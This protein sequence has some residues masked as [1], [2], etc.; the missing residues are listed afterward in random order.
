[1]LAGMKVELVAAL[2]ASALAAQPVPEMQ[3]ETAKLRAMAAAAPH[4]P[5]SMTDIR[6]LAPKPDWELGFVSSAAAAP[7]GTVYLLQ[8]GLTS[9]PVVVVDRSGHVIRSWGKGLYKIPHSIRLDSAGDVWTV[10]AASSRVLKFSPDG[11]LLLEIEVGG[12]PQTRSA[13]NGAAD[14]AFSKSGRVFVADGYGNARVVEYTQ[15]GAKVREWGTPGTGPGQ[16]HLPHGIA[17]DE[18]D[19]IFVADRE[20]G[21]IQRFTLEGAY[22]GEFGGLG[23]TFSVTVAG[24]AL[25]IGTQPRD[26]PNGAPG[27]LMKLDRK[28]GKVLGVVESPG[29][30][31]VT[32]TAQGEMFTGVRPD[33]LLWFKTRQK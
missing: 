13:F 18:D 17:I 12:Q 4:L 26:E 3:A 7:D 29:H 20:N 19:T 6:I 28:T 15:R 10:D 22:R 31:S 1:M 11:R 24:G 23:K 14:V 27:W 16:F 8:R 33:R 9:D 30:H 5:L 2:A 21:R 32:V 25:W